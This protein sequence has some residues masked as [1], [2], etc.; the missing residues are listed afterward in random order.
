MPKATTA[1]VP[2]KPIPTFEEFREAVKYLL[3]NDHGMPKLVAE[4]IL[5][6]DVDFLETNHGL[7]TKLDNAVAKT[8]D[9]FAFEPVSGVTWVQLKPGMRTADKDQVVIDVGGEMG[10]YLERLVALGLHGA[11]RDAVASIMLARGI[12]SVFPLIAGKSAIGSR[13]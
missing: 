6:A 2:T 9:S 8:A 3:L 7:F 4:E 5:S 12:E 11:E 10:R 13:N 1:S